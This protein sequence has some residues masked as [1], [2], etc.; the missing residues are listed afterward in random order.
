MIYLVICMFMN[1]YE[2]IL[3]SIY[4]IK[5]SMKIL[6]HKY[7][8]IILKF[9][10]FLLILKFISIELCNCSEQLDVQKLFEV[11]FL[12][13]NWIWCSEHGKL[14]CSLRSLATF[15]ILLSS[16]KVSF[17]SLFI[18]M[19]QIIIQLLTKGKKTFKL[20]FLHYFRFAKQ[21]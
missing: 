12:W 14:L 21:N 11:A 16:R 7:F 17:C 1:D 6:L 15:F 13:W 3:Y 8:L 4:S 19:F 20:R 9:N 5:K 18:S 2:I 10:L